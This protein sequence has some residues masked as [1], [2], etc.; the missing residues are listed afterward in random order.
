[1]IILA[2]H[3]DDEVIGC[4]RQLLTGSVTHVLYFFELTETRKAESIESSRRFNFIPIYVDANKSVDLN[5]DDVLLVPHIS[6]NHPHHKYVNQWAKKLSNKKLYY[7]IDMVR[8]IEPLPSDISYLKRTTLLQLFPSQSK[9]FEVAKYY[10][11]ESKLVDSDY[12]K[13]IGIRTQFEGVHCYPDAPEEVAYLRNPHRHIF[14]VYV[15]L[16]VFHNDRELE[17]IMFRHEI[18]KLIAE[19]FDGLDNKSCEMIADFILT[20]TINK[21]N[22]RSCQVTVSEDGENE[23]TLTYTF[24]NYL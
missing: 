15:K 9:L 19:K 23:A 7:S 11:F 8:N 1:M 3:V 21:Y 2:P 16:E 6:D 24:V 14:H 17:F 22:Q 20:Y 5:A 10:L 12:T 18:N 13:S 4:F